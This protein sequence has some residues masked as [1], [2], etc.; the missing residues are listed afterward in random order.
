MIGEAT[1]DGTTLWINTEIGCVFRMKC[2]G[3]FIPTT[4]PIMVD[5][6]I[7]GLGNNAAIEVVQLMEGNREFSANFEI[8]INPNGVFEVVSMSQSKYWY[9][10]FREASD[11]GFEEK[12]VCIARHPND[13][14]KCKR[15]YMEGMKSE[16]L[17]FS[18]FEI[19]NTRPIQ[20]EEYQR[21]I[22]GGRRWCLW[23]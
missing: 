19:T 23:S 6:N 2:D 10:E 7:N 11:D 20:K 21:F 14:I 13:W 8:V 3:V 5:V 4:E 17:P 18:T 1:T 12:S 15:K 9:V 22:V 16:G